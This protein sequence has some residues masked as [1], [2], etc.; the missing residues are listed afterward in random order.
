[1]NSFS[2]ELGEQCAEKLDQADP[3]KKYRNE[4]YL[5]R[6]SDGKACLYFVGNSLGLQ[7]KKARTYAEEVF[8]DWEKLA[9]EGHQAGK[10]PWYPYH[11]VLTESTARL[12]GAKPIEVVVMNIKRPEP[13]P[14]RFSPT[15][16]NLRSKVIRPANILGILIMKS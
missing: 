8:S 6:K 15:G 12:V 2:F 3:I 10:H 5:P 11:E 13:M 14:K 16:R 4:F 1:M 9:V 7:P